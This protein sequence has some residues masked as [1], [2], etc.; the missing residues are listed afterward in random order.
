VLPLISLLGGDVTA[1]WATHVGQHQS[2]AQHSDTHQ[3]VVGQKPLGDTDAGSRTWKRY[4]LQ[5]IS[6]YGADL[7]PVAGQLS[8]SL[9]WPRGHVDL[10]Q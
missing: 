4:A 5:E 6:L 8:I 10:R 1:G 7:P 9:K 2:D 3:R